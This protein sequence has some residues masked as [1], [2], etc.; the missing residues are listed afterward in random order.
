[1]PNGGSDN[2]AACGFNEVNRGE[3]AHPRPP[4]SANAYCTIRSIRVNNP[5]WTYCWWK[6]QHPGVKLAWD[7]D[8]D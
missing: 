3:W 2:C 5:L 6:E 7:Y 8:W 1:M 4:V